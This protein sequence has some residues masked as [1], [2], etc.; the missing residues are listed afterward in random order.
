[1][2]QDKVRIVRSLRARRLSIT[3]KP[4]G[5]V[6]LT[7]PRGVTEQEALRFL[8]SKKEWI[9]K[10]RARLA[11]RQ[12]SKEVIDVPYSTKFHRLELTAANTLTAAFKVSDGAMRITYPA[13]ADIASESI[14]NVIR[15][16]I[17]E[18][19]RL[20]AKRYLPGRV[21][22]IAA[23]LGFKH[24]NV[25][26]RNSRTRWGSCSGTNNISLSLHLMK[27]PYELIDYIIIHELCHTVHKNHG[28]KFHALL[29]KHTG[30][31]H[32]GLRKELK[33]YSTRW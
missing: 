10:A 1:M 15:Q 27:L 28:V 30:G 16:A 4:G 14:Q 7:I 2:E 17:E 11:G 29:D 19:W 23:R 22:E 9:D 20:E 3:V 12:R 13:G 18:A 31:R 25:A 5:E 8:E 26:I 21:T 24:G 33:K 6:R 32:P